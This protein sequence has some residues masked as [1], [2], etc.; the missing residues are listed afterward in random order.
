MRI[1][2]GLSLNKWVKSHLDGRGEMVI[3]TSMTSVIKDQNP[4][5]RNMWEAATAELIELGLLCTEESPRARPSMLDAADDLDR[6]KRYLSGNT[7]TTF[8]SSLGMSSSTVGN[9]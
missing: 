8:A 6:L 4:D 1:E 7:T 3:D 2:A 9:D 5:V